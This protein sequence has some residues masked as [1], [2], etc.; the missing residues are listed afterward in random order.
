MAMKSGEKLSTLLQL[1]F[2]QKSL[3]FS[4]KS[5]DLKKITRLKKLGKNTI[6]R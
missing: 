2:P 1:A 5:L 6:L 3:K 4:K